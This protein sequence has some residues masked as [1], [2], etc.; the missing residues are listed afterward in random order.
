MTMR[1]STSKKWKAMNTIACSIMI[2]EATKPRIRIRTTSA[3][4]EDPTPCNILKPTLD[5][6][7]KIRTALDCAIERS[8]VNASIALIN[9]LVA[10][11]KAADEIRKN[12]GK[13]CDG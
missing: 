7:D 8:D 4:R 9:A 2:F 11:T 12:I 6:L 3:R 13:S 5:A 1:L 10:L